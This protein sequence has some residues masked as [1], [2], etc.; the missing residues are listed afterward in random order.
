[1]KSIKY[2]T[3]FNY[4]SLPL[5]VALTMSSAAAANADYSSTIL[6]DHPAAYYR[7]EEAPGA[8]T[9]ADSSGNGFNGGINYDYDINGNPDY[10]RLGQNGIDT[11]SYLFHNYADTNYETHVSDVEVPYNATLNPQGPFSVE[12]WARATSDANNYDVPVGSVGSYPNGWDF[13][14]TPGTPGSWVFNP[15][16]AFIQTSQVVKNQWT[17]LVGVYDGTNFIFYINGVAT[18]TV[19]GSGYVANSANDLYIGGDPPTGWGGFEGYVDEVAIYTNALTAAQ[20]LA[21][22]QAGTNSFSTNPAPPEVLMDAGATNS[23][24]PSISVNA[25]SAATFDP[26]VVG[27]TPLSYQWFTN[28]VLDASQTGSLLT[29]TASSADDSST[30]FVVVTNN[31]G[32]STSQVATLTVAGALFINGNP[33]SIIR[34]VGSYAAFHVT[35]S[36]A[37]PIT[38][39]WS[40]STDGGN[41]FTTIA[42]ETN[43]T[44]WLS[45]V[46]LAQSGYEYSATVTG[47]VISTNTPPALLTVQARAVNVPLTGYGAIVAADKP[48]AYWRLDEPLGSSTA[49]DAVGSFNGT[50]TVGTAGGFNFGVPTGIPNSTDPAVGLTNGVNV[51]AANGSSIQI[52]FAPELNPDT[53]WSIESWVQPYSLGINENDYRVVLSSEYNLYPN[54]YNGWYLYQQPSDTFAF[55][56]EPGNAFIVA[57]PIVA[58]NWYYLVVTDDGTNFNFYINGVLAVAPVPVAGAGYIPNGSG[59]NTDGTAGITSGLG[60]TVLGQRTDAAFNS[61]DGS[62]D[63]TAIYNYALTPQ[64]VELHYLD[65]VN[66]TITQSGSNVILNWPTGTLQQSTNVAGSY[67]DVGGATSPFTNSVSGS[68]QMF[69]RVKVQ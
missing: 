49:V 34:N 42:G 17:H 65:T 16:G 13:Y 2:P 1:M 39:Q 68:S 51:L 22:Y 54:P 63:D 47:P 69:Y 5:A 43:D 38:Y 7:L 26:I 48:V 21:H 8:G 53:A 24:P 4:K 50:Y 45:N 29:F 67:S 10:P 58:N 44:L 19:P 36:G 41:T 57:G 20:V 12:F 33:Q 40:L 66:L 56:P 60:N 11:N 23:N 25:G 15:N 9:A 59:I 61:F 64:Q 62:I 32:S 18:A 30:Y 28:G 14:Q 3:M 35:A 6:A 27:A 55:V 46:Q 52:P 37:S 31:Y